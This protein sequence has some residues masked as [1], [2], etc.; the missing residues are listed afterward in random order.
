MYK[1]CS[2][3][4]QKVHE[5]NLKDVLKKKK[6][7]QKVKEALKKVKSLQKKAFSRASLTKEADRVW[8]LYIRERDRGNPCITCGVEWSESHQAGHFMSRRHLNTRWE[9]FNGA[10]QCPKCNCW[11][12][13]EQYEFS[14]ALERKS[15]WLPEQLR[16]LALSTEKVTDDEILSYIKMLYKN[17]DELQIDYKPKKM[18]R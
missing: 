14:L 17:L 3:K 11:G 16:R 8:S 5:K 13:W 18:Y 2:T 10:S 15:K 9:V 12:A 1:T 4:C 7:D 6:E